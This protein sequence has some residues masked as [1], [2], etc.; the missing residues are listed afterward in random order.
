MPDSPHIRLLPP[1]VANKIAAGEVVERPASVLK[2]LFENAIDSGATQVDVA[3]VA[4]GSRLVSVADNGSGMDRDDA[5]LSV[6]RHATSKIR[7]ADDIGHIR[8]LGFRGEALA[9]ISSVCRF[10][11]CT[12]RASDL[13]G[14]E[15]IMSGG[16]MQDLREA[17]CPPGT[18]IEVRDLFFNMPARRKFLRSPQT[19]T[20]HLRQTFL[21]HALGCPSVGMKLTIDGRDAWA[22]AGGSTH[23]ERIRELFG[24]EMMEGLRPVEGRSDAASLTGFVSLPTLNRGD[25]GEQYVFINGRPSTAP[26]INYAIRE[27]YHNLL[28]DGRHPYVF[29]FIELPPEAVDVNVHPTKRE[30]RFR[31]PSDIRDLIISGIRRALTESGGE[32]IRGKTDSTTPVVT[33]AMPAQTA[34]ASFKVDDLPPTRVLGYPRPPAP[35][36]GVP[37]SVPRQ[38]SESAVPVVPQRETPGASVGKSPW[39]WCRIVGQV[40]GLYVLMETEDGYVVM[41]PHAAHERVL[42]ERFMNAVAGGTIE[43]QGLLVPESVELPPR[44]AMLVRKNLELLKKMGIGVSEF[45]GDTFMVDAMPAGFSDVRIREMLAD[46]AHHLETLG[47]RGSNTRWREEAIA[48]AACKAATKA[49]DRLSLAEL[50]RLV[51]QLAATEMPYTCPH[52]RPTLIHTSFKE[53]AKRFGRE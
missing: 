36:T 40:G 43:S 5:L 23:G 9:A 46:V 33:D 37:P 17:G 39:S 50:E 13:A 52:G 42:F 19:E 53:L 45:G 14:S 31:Q 51:L 47:E 48:Q 49:R 41:D 18:L 10:R 6:E 26:V 22:L 34:F 1:D 7:D 2:E 30:V 16:K 24:R 27:A 20:G 3:I 25:R 21:V 35:E 15:L 8:T 28:A 11:M 38:G 12:R 44:D 32:F 29:L 4:G